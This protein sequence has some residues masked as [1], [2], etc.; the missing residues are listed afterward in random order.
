MARHDLLMR[1]PLLQLQQL[2]QS[3]L[4]RGDFFARLDCAVKDSAVS[5]KVHAMHRL[6][7]PLA[8]SLLAQ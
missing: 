3:P 4:P 8:H 7:R 2:K 6:V 5:A 1:L